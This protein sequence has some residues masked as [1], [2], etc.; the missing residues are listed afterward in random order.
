MA[1]SPRGRQTK[2]ADFAYLEEV[3]N[4]VQPLSEQSPIW[5]RHGVVSQGLA[6]PT[7]ERHPCCELGIQL[8][9]DGIELVGTE[10]AHRGPGDVL[11]V[12]PGVPHWIEIT[13]YPIQ[14]ITVF[15]LPGLLLE[16]VPTFDGLRM[17]R[18][19][20]GRLGIDRRLVRPAGPL[21][22]IVR[23][24]FAEMVS[25]F[26]KTGFGREA[27][28]RALLLEMIIRLMRWEDESEGQAPCPAIADDPLD[29]KRVQDA[30]K[31]L[32]VRYASPVY[33]YELAE[34]SGVSEVK[35]KQLFRD[36][37]GMSW[38]RYLQ[39]YRVQHSATLLATSDC[40]VLEAALASGFET[41][42]HFNSTFRSFIGVSPREYRRRAKMQTPSPA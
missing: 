35:L 7:A 21:R 14:F 41:M 1:S 36:A 4:A 2:P 10:R 31:Y 24:C 16:L 39:N 37:L 23:D 30:L 19:F 29:W 12:G 27:R 13:R 18:R 38:N 20:T 5:V 25:E 42:S 15:F 28:L 6:C 40:G 11:L 3:S 33:A 17:L 9:G 22:G 32:R 26:E 34:A 8:K